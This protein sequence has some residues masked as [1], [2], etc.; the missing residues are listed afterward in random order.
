MHFQSGIRQLLL[1]SKLQFKGYKNNFLDLGS[2]LS[3]F[4][5]I[6]GNYFPPSHNF[7]LIYFVYYTLMLE[8]CQESVAGILYLYTGI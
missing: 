1:C 2:Q 8:N 4:S 3:R 6:T 7:Y 5:V